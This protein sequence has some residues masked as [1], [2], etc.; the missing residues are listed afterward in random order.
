MSTSEGA[1]IES[2]SAENRHLRDELARM[3]TQLGAAEDVIRF[4]GNPLNY[5]PRLDAVTLRETQT[6]LIDDDEPATNRETV[7]LG[8]RK[9]R[10]YFKTYE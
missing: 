10:R 6:E 5:K 9:A 4:Y 1:L 8:G 3:K 7:R 2:L